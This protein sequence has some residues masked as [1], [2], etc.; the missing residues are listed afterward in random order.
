MEF[1]KMTEQEVAS[2]RKRNVAIGISL[3]V[4]S[5]LFMITTMIRVYEN[6]NAG[7]N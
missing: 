3:A 7:V 5:L 4:L 2:R 6:M 1:R